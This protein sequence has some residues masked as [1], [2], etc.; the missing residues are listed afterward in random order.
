MMGLKLLSHM[1]EQCQENQAGTNSNMSFVS[2]ST[3]QET[4]AYRCVL[5]KVVKKIIR[6]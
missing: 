5:T 4:V 3:K 6:Y 1:N 2:C